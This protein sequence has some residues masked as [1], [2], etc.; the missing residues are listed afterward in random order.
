MNTPK[1]ADIDLEKYRLR[2]F[3]DRLESSH[4]ARRTRIS[5]R[6]RLEA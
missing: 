6:R 1:S 3:V 5:F 4:V 2:R